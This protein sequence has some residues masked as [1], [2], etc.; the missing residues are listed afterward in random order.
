[1]PPKRP[2]SGDPSEQSG[3]KQTRLDSDRPSPSPVTTAK[4]GKE[5]AAEIAARIA[6]KNT[7]ATS[8]RTPA[9]MAR[10]KLDEIRAKAAAATGMISKPAPAAK[11]MTPAETA[12]AKLAEIQARAAAA[13]KAQA[14]NATPQ[15]TPAQQARA[16][17]EEIQRAKAGLLQSNGAASSRTASPGTFSV[18]VFDDSPQARGGLRVGLHPS[19]LGNAVQETGLDG[20][21][22]VGSESPATDMQSGIRSAEMTD[23]PYFDPAALESGASKRRPH[24]KLAFNPRGK[25]I[26]QGNAMRQQARIEE[27]KKAMATQMKK[28]DMDEENEKPFLVPAPPEIE[29]WDEG[30]VDGKDYEDLDV[31][32][33]I[34]IDTD[35][36]IV[37]SYVQHPVQMEPPQDKNRP[38]PKPLFLTKKEQA[39]VRRMKRA[40]ITKEQ[41]AKI[42][43]G[44]EPP[45]PPKIKK[46]NLMRVLGEQ[47][48]KD[49]TAVEARVNREIAERDRAH[50]ETNEARK[51]TQEQKQEKVEEQ[52]RKDA[53]KGIYVAVF[54][55]D[56]LCYGKHRYQIDVNAKEWGLTGITIFH[57]SFNLVII[58]GGDRAVSQYKK[59]ML[60]RMRWHEN[61]TPRA[62]KEG[63]KEVEAAF[64]S[65]V[66][67]DGSLKDLSQNK[68]QLVWEG[69]QRSRVFKK[70]GT[71]VCHTDSEAKE[72]L[73]RTKMSNMWTQARA[74]T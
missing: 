52:R 74:M 63:S 28:A 4:T 53:A 45:P 64:L 50:R 38:A 13:A 3:I 32:G 26:M 54:K 24:R 37:L 40:A 62:P 71:R 66:N 61:D 36:T 70:W 18:A 56:D 67:E 7:Q 10:A 33:K 23:N 6:A 49:P 51:L 12:R 69:K 2:Y 57:P 16:K 46:S 5:R 14:G 21:R 59:L 48:V 41:Q 11:E 47:A 30:L 9:Q 34:K 55:I 17:L 20:N 25:Y 8:E 43:L 27:M 68:C 58:E 72:L 60:H 1:M 15:L 29:W 65:Q 31:P 19:L 73:E 22:H 42:R 39:K 35:D 44:L